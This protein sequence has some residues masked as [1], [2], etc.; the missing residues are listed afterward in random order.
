MGRFGR[1]RLDR[2]LVVLLGALLALVGARD[3][4]AQD[5]SPSLGVGVH[6]QGYSFDDALGADVANLLLFPVA[7]RLPVGD[8]FTA[9]VYSAYGRGAVERGGAVFELEGLV[10]TRIRA[11]YQASSWA[12]LTVGV[13]LPSG[14][15]E[16]N[17]AEALVASV[18]STDLLG[19]RESNFGT[20]S[21]V[22]GGLATARRFGAWGIGLA[23]SYRLSGEFEPR[24]D[25]AL[26]YEPGNEIRIRAAVDRTVGEGGK[27][28]LG[29]TFQNFDADQVSGRNLFQ[30]GNRFRGDASLVFRRGRSTWTVYGT[31]IHRE[32]GDAFLDLIDDAG[33]IVG[34]TIV[35]TG[36]QNLFVVGLT[37]SV[38]LTGTYRIRPTLD[39][40][41]QDREEG[42]GSGWILGAG[43]DLP[44]RLFG[45]WDVFPRG[46]FLVG[47][48]EDLQGIR[49]GMWGGELGLTVRLSG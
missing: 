27:V 7:A 8:R 33:V 43:G 10:D 44:L 9:E 18:L 45:S 28:T 4:G 39:L 32:N 48:M 31:G 17:S 35:G 14:N 16:H 40:R 5:S 22:A 2:S 42:Q 15:S 6:F 37:G 12:V 41:I 23:G 47:Q 38:P 1:F 11:V 34:D 21:G 24:A 49:R 36:S 20:G 13:N 19:F 26:S 3:L 25:T 30:A 46:R 29:F